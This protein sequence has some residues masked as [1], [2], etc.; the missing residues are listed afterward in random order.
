[1]LGAMTSTEPMDAATPDRRYCKA[2]RSNG[3]PCHK[4]PVK[5]ALVCRVHG[6]AAPQ[7][8]DAAR[9]RLLEAADPAAA[10]LVELLDNPDPAIAVRAAVA[11]LDRAG[12]GPSSTQVQVDGGQVAYRIEGVDLDAL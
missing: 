7:V 11:L 4:Y 8:R 10:R 3:Q 1:M 5:G 12:H 9:R 6:G 2:R